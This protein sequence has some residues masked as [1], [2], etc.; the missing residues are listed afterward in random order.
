MNHQ[1]IIRAELLKSRKKSIINLKGVKPLLGGQMPMQRNQN[2]AND[3]LPEV[4]VGRQDEHKENIQPRGKTPG[5][6]AR[7]ANMVNS[8]K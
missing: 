8:T 6:N 2:P 1:S 7:R 5:G 3:S 4:R